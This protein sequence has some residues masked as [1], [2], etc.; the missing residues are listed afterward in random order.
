MVRIGGESM[1]DIND[2]MDPARLLP[3]TAS[4]QPLPTTSIIFSVVFGISLLSKT[5]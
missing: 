5:V 4:I 3:D 2:S 1:R